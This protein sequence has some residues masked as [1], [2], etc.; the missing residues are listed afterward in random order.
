MNKR[1]KIEGMITPMLQKYCLKSILKRQCQLQCIARSNNAWRPFY[2]QSNSCFGFQSVIYFNHP[3]VILAHF[4]RIVTTK[5]QRNVYNRYLLT[6]HH[7]QGKCK[8]M[9]CGWHCLFKTIAQF[10]KQN[11]A[12]LN[13]DW[14]VATR[15]SLVH[16]WTEILTG[17]KALKYNVT[18]T[19]PPPPPP[20]N[21]SLSH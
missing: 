6:F 2:W 20:I 1:Y 17:K 8:Q 9:H 13:T 4:N 7:F 18:V 21:I 3:T 5:H 10:L 12:Q 19:M 14:R 15:P 16:L 11:S